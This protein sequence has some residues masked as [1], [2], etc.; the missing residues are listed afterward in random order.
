MINP[1]ELIKTYI[2]AGLSKEEAIIEA[3]KELKERK[4]LSTLSEIKTQNDCMNSRE[5]DRWK[6]PNS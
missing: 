5:R 4:A 1:N 6:Q 2:D 3:K